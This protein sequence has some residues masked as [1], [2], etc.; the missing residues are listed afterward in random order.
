MKQAKSSFRYNNKQNCIDM[1]HLQ[2]LIANKENI[3]PCY[4]FIEKFNVKRFCKLHGYK[5]SVIPGYYKESLVREKVGEIHSHLRNIK[6]F[7]CDTVIVHLN[8]EK[9]MDHEDIKNLLRDHQLDKR[10]VI[11]LT[12]NNSFEELSGDV[13]DLVINYKPKKTG[14]RIGVIS[15]KISSILNS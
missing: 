15:R 5:Y 7:G 12:N 10:I 4:F 3:S 2:K 11:I 14:F 13:T 9:G 1:N 8:Y 6:R